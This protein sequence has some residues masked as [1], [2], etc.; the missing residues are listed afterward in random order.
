MNDFKFSIININTF[1]I[2]I[3]G[4]S[5]NHIKKRNG[6]IVCWGK[7]T[8]SKSVSGGS[9]QDGTAITYPTTFTS[10]PSVNVTHF[11]GNQFN[12]TVVN[13]SVTGF[14]PR[15]RNVNTNTSATTIG[16]YWIAIGY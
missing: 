13:K 5:N 15:Y 12:M 16:C 3:I 2:R 6:L 7:Q 10:E 8:F 9:N 11:D 1:Y 4:L 14:T